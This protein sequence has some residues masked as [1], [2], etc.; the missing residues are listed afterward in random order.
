MLSIVRITPR[1]PN[2]NYKEMWTIFLFGL[3]TGKFTMGSGE[4]LGSLPPSLFPEDTDT[5][6]Y[7]TVILDG[8]DKPTIHYDTEFHTSI[9]WGSGAP[10]LGHPESWAPALAEPD[11]R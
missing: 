4:P 10:A 7:D 1:T 5:Q 11:C 9:G 3:A 6:E 2:T 8:P